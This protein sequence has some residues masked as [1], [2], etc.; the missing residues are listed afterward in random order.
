MI[1]KLEEVVQDK[2]NIIHNLLA[3]SNHF[4]MEVGRLHEQL[5][6]LR[7][8]EAAREQQEHAD[9]VVEDQEMVAEAK[10][11]PIFTC[12]VHKHRFLYVFRLKFQNLPKFPILCFNSILYFFVC[13]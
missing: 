1:E 5:L 2:N 6:E 11:F 4:A 7:E 12:H 13:P 8:Q 10:I 9:G 3:R